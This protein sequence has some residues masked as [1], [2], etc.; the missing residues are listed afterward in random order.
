MRR[1]SLKLPRR[2]WFDAYR[3]P[4]HSADVYCIP[5]SIIE[6]DERILSAEEHAATM[7][8]RFEHDRSVY[9]KAHSAARNILAEYCDITPRELQ[10]ERSPRGK[11]HIKTHPTVYFSLSHNETHVALAV[12]PH[13]VGVDIESVAELPEY[14]IIM[15][16]YFTANERALVHIAPSPLR[17]FYETWVIKEAG[18]KCLDISVDTLNHRSTG[19]PSTL[20][21]MP[22]GIVGAVAWQ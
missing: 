1:S 2:V 15:D 7:R 6:Y 13:E 12:A 10:F 11:P 21:S 8:K 4:V 19:P 20:L 5:L 16:Q 22:K 9:R 18:I 14:G 17:M 3:Q